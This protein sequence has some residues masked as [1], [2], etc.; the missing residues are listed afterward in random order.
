MHLERLPLP[1]PGKFFPPPCDAEAPPHR[2]APP[3]EQAG[4]GLLLAEVDNSPLIVVKQV[5]PRG[6][7]HR[8][9]RVRV[10]DQILR[11]S[12]VDATTGMGVTDLRNLIV[13]EQGTRVAIC[14]R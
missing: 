11:V 2:R 13:G 8:S 12:G 5:V 1:W 3:A 9:G 10:G 4:V 14:F 6:A 7:A